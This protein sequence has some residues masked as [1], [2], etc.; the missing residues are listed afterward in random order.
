M[1]GEEQP[2]SNMMVVIGKGMSYSRIEAM[3]VELSVLIPCYNEE[4]N[5]PEL[6]ERTE[7]VFERRGITGEIILVDDGSEDGTGAEIDTLAAT[8]PGVIALHHPTNRGMAAAWKSALERSRGRYVLTIDADLQYQPE[9]IAQLHREMCFSKADLVQGWRSPLE[10]NTS[11]IRYYLS[12]GLD[13][14]LKIAFDMQQHDVKSG[15]VIYKREVFEEILAHAPGY[16]YFQ[17]FVAV[18]AKAKGFSIRQVETLFEQR[19]AGR[20]FIGRLP[21]G[22]IARTFV[23]LG[24]ALFEF[25]FREPKDQSLALAVADRA[26]PTS[27]DEPW[28]RRYDLAYRALIP[29]HHWAISRNAPR[30]LDELRRT[31][32]L[33]REQIEHLQLRRLRRLVQHASEHVG[34]YRELFLTAGITPDSIRTLDDLRRIPVLSKQALRENLYFDLLSDNHDKQKI[35]KIVTS[36][37]VPA[38][39]ALGQHPAER[40][41]DRLPL[42]RP[43]GPALALDDRPEA[44]PGAQGAARCAPLAAEVLL[45]VRAR[46]P[47]APALRRVRAPAAAGAPRRVRGGIQRDRHAARVTA[48]G[49]APGGGDHLLGA[50]APGGDPG[51]RRAA[52]RLP[53]LRQ[54][55][56]ARV[57]RHR[58]RVR[59]ARRL[60]RERRE[61]HRGG[62][63]RRPA[64]GRW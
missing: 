62:R 9:A 57:Q 29:V 19:R 51:A 27:N 63:P 42:P 7:R 24:R 16:F 30:Y 13:Y 21:V 22:V 59:G 2:N 5:L 25:R 46:R 33:P 14:L 15:F 34:Y 50:D 55:R 47:G 60:P 58:A 12:R 39:H 41:V 35:Q 8:R 31:Q 48:G 52:V 10:R 6:V 18:A 43:P 49:R 61:L 17:T 23:D 56:C 11:D 53:R 3:S 54:I 38:R 64:R 37:P 45:G 26:A 32:W 28:R 36:G 44:T 1:A 20:S 4:G 40:R